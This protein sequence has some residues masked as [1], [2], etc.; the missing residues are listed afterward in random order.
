V[1]AEMSELI[2]N[3][4]FISFRGT[5][6]VFSRWNYQFST[7]STAWIIALLIFLY[8]YIF[9]EDILT[10]RDPKWINFNCSETIVLR[11]GEWLLLAKEEMLN[12]H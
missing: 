6:S 12:G 10:K 5:S 9:F 8:I 11:A 7:P 2:L 1:R 3:F 4:Y